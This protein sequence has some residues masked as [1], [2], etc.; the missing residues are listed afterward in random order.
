MTKNEF[1]T[2][3][4]KNLDSLKAKIVKEYPKVADSIENDIVEFYEHVIERLEQIKSPGSYL[5]TWVY[6]RN[7]RYYQKH[8]NTTHI[9]ISEIPDIPEEEDPYQEYRDKLD[10]LLDNL[11]LDMQILYQLYYVQGLTTREIAKI[12]GLTHVGIHK[13][14]KRMQAKLKTQLCSEQ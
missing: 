11:P 8:K 1:D 4:S 7:F 12:H 6:N 14:L 5:Y 13:Q 3:C 9:D 10:I 2:W